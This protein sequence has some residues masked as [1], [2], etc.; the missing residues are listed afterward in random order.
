M[1]LAEKLLEHYLKYRMPQSCVFF[2]I[3]NMD[4]S[5]SGVCYF[6]MHVLARA[7]GV[8][9]V[10]YPGILVTSQIQFWQPILAGLKVLPATI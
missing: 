2:S 8:E 10:W 7:G 9:K 3:G 1:C 6:L 5:L 4:Y